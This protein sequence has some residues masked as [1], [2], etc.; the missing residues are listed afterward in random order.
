M[1]IF[2]AKGNVYAAKGT[3]IISRP[4][5][6]DHSIAVSAFA[7]IYELSFVF[8]LLWQPACDKAPAHWIINREYHHRMIDQYPLRDRGSWVAGEVRLRI[9]KFR[10]R[11]VSLTNINIFHFS[12]TSGT[13]QSISLQRSSPVYFRLY[14]LSSLI[15]RHTETSNIYVNS[16]MSR[17]IDF[18]LI[19][20]T[21]ESLFEIFVRYNY[22]RGT[23]FYI[24]LLFSSNLIALRRFIF[25]P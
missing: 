16:T 5:R 24:A 25:K 11:T 13:I 6:S 20:S 10:C 14:A 22:Y 17:N 4:F 15:E 1:F 9:A 3:P 21:P 18:Y 12:E 8:F 7:D 23:I 2:L 19:I